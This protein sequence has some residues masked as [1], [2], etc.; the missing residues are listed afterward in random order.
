MFEAVLFDLDDTLT[1]WPAALA[2]AL[3]AGLDALGL[4]GELLA[5][6]S[7]WDEI[8][9]YTHVLR[10]GLVVDRAYWRL[11]FEPQVPFERAFPLESREAVKAAAAAFRAALNPAPFAETATA[12]DA[13]QASGVR[14][15]VLSNNPMAAFILRQHGLASRFKAVVSPD[16]PYKKPHPRAFNDACD[17]IGEK[18]SLSA[19]VGDSYL[20]DVEG[21]HAAGLT[22]IWLDRAGD[23]YPLPPAALRVTSLAE[24][25][26]LLA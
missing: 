18:P 6:S 23:G 17:A 7:A 20:N 25:V 12:L 9:G 26:A 24:L 21:A 14:M 11:L 19:Y 8:V 1:D 15:G 22:A 3:D 4:G 2:I 16:D 13:L 10:G 5:R